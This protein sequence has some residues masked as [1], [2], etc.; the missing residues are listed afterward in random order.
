MMDRVVRGGVLRDLPDDGSQRLRALVAMLQKQ[1]PQLVELY[2]NTASLKDR[3]V[4]TGILSGALARQFACGGYVGRASGRRFD[5]RRTPGYP[6]YEALQF[7]VP[8]V[9]AGD[10]NA[11]IWIRIR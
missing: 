9:E 1:F 10:V 3:T 2:E 4:D 8:V 6:P 5:A 7:E 11:R